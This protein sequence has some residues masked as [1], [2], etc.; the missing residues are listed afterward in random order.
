MTIHGKNDDEIETLNKGPS[1]SLKSIIDKIPGQKF[2]TDEFLSDTIKSKYYTA[3]EFLA[4]KFSPR[5]FSIIHLNISSLQ[6]HID[7]L[8]SLLFGLELKFDIICISETRLY[9]EKP[10]VNIN[11]DGYT[12]L[13]TPTE[14]RAGGVGMYIN[15]CLEFYKIES[16]SLCHPSVCES[17]FVEIKH[18]T[19]K[20]LIVGTIYRHPSSAVSDFLNTF[21][22]QSLQKITKSNKN[23]ILAGD[24]NVDLINYGHN[25]HVDS[26]YDEIS[27]FS[28]RPLILQPSR[29]TSKSFTLI[30]NIFI[31]DLSCFSSG[32]NITSSISDHFSQFCLIDIFKK[33]HSA[34]NVKY[35]RDWRNFNRERFTYEIQNLSWD[36]VIPPEFDTNDSLSS[37]YGKITDLLDEMA[38]IKRLTKKEQGL[39]ERPWITFGISISIKSRD[40]CY[41]EFL[42]EKDKTLKSLKFNIYKQKRNM[43]T[44][45]IRLSKKKFYSDFFIENQTNVKKTWEGIRQL[46][47]VSKE[48]NTKISKLSHNDS[49]LTAP[50]DMANSMNSFF[51][52]IG[53]S[54]EE[55]IPEVPTPITDYLGEPNRYS[56]TL[57]PCTENEING[58]IDRL[59]I[60]KASGP[61][62]VPSK[63]LKTH[64]EALL[65]PLTAI[66]NKSLSEGTFPNLLKSATVVPIFKKNDKE[67]C[68]NYRPIS[69]LSNLSKIFERAM[70]DRIELFLDEFEIIYSKQFGFRK[71]YSTNHAL[72]SIVEQ[73][74]KNMDN[75]IFSCGVF[76]DLE[77]A[78]DTVNHGILIEKLNH[79][80]ICNNAS[81]WILSYLCNRSQHVKLNGAESTNK[82]VTC[83][84]PQGS[85]LGPLLFIIYI[86]DMHKALLNSKVFH[87]ADDTNLLFSSKTPKI[88]KMINNELKLLFEW[89][90]ANRLSLNVAKTEFIIFR[91]HRKGLDKRVYLKLNGKKIFESTKIKYLGIL[92]DN[93]LSW[94][95]H[96]N[97]LSKKLN[98][99]IGM[100][101]KI[102]DLCTPKVLRSLY[103]SLFNSHLTYGLSVWGNC[104]A[105]YSN[106]LLVSQKKIVRAISFAKF[107]APSKPLF[108]ELNILR[109]DDL[110]KS[111]IASLMW[112]YDHG[113]LP[114]DL[115]PLFLRRSSVHSRNLRNTENQRLYTSTYRNSRFGSN[116]IS[117][118]GSSLLNE[119]KDM[120]LYQTISKKSFMLKYKDLLLNRY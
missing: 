62:S 99:A 56:I 73:V 75:K 34:S 16:I 61:F 100:I 23:C 102:R 63:I 49:T 10:L 1:F 72:I 84:V 77:K 6:K 80:G 5:N 119:L 15:S 90:C 33:S 83:G 91:P 46:L 116:S 48:N 31:N 32:G 93:R 53:K 59:D 58:F 55:K 39:I 29:V 96:I 20:N 51:V 37:F 95:H 117:Q 21:F 107:S 103:F 106:K 12:F 105:T 3:G 22:R 113:T 18:P 81:N 2:T 24:F 118:F 69:L 120:D 101:Y 35:S 85:I 110:Y 43:I 98:S 70:Y 57:N 104:N 112:D 86:N 9:D 67:K 68:S 8:R 88:H 44:S 38:P 64:K 109:F 92:L 17:I 87:F 60:S 71:K 11:I 89:L 79:Y 97:E 36:D 66:V 54:V 50:K 45:L 13:H 4:A 52:N 14:T 78:F 42:E 47:N 115:N 76:V 74:R 114:E 82:N 28:F 94:K 108:K 27:R 19:K 30:D 25:N 40:I 7:E 111:Q 26:F 41:K 65:K